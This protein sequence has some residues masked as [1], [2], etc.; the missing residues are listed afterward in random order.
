MKHPWYIPP[1]LLDNLI[2]HFSNISQAHIRSDRYK[3][4]CPLQQTAV[5]VICSSNFDLL[6]VFLLTQMRLFYAVIYQLS[7]IKD[8]KFLLSY[9]L[10]LNLVEHSSAV[11]FIIKFENLNSYCKPTGSIIFFKLMFYTGI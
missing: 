3:A 1:W 11:F 9:I 6:F 2:C 10:H 5:S 4:A 7:Y 8:R